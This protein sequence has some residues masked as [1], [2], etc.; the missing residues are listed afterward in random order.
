M[1]LAES[2]DF[3]GIT[4]ARFY[5]IVIIVDCFDMTESKDSVPI[6]AS[7]WIE[8]KQV[9]VSGVATGVNVQNRWCHC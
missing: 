8:S 5:N 9:L 6:R 4:K 3:I 7:H 1:F 2:N